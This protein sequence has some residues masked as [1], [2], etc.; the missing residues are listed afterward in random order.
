M[1]RRARWQKSIIPRV[2]A[3]PFEQLLPSRTAPETVPRVRQ[4][5]WK[6]Y[7]RA[8]RW[9]TLLTAH[10]EYL[11]PRGV[12]GRLLGAAPV[13]GAPA[14]EVPRPLRN[15][16][17]VRAAVAESAPARSGAAH[18]VRVPA[19][20]PEPAPFLPVVPRSEDQP[21]TVRRQ[22]EQKH[23]HPL[24]YLDPT[25]LLR[26]TPPAPAQYPTPAD[27]R[28]YHPLP[29]ITPAQRLYPNDTL[30]LIAQKAHAILFRGT[31]FPTYRIPEVYYLDTYS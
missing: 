25:P 9:H 1:L 31:P 17:A 16:D 3:P 26:T 28:R 11:R 30:K 19:A 14:A 15:V 2:Q 5:Q 4:T 7:H 20:A 12:V 6:P 27:A 10:S 18:A 21:P 24:P 8:G 13:P 23:R 29:T 22:R